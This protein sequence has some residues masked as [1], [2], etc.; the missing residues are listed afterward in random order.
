MQM[1]PIDDRLIVWTRIRNKPAAASEIASHI[2]RIPDAFTI[3][4]WW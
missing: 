3:S 4:H 1:C 2:F